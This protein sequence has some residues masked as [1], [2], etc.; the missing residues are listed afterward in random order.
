MPSQHALTLAAGDYYI[1]VDPNAYAE[2]NI[3]FRVNCPGL[4]PC[5]TSP[6]YPPNNS[7]LAV[8]GTG[9]VFTWPAAFGATSYDVYFQGNYVANTPTN[10]INGGSGYSTANIAA[11]FGIGN[12]ITWRVVPRNSFGEADCPTN[13]TFRVG[14]NGSAN[15]IPLSEGVVRSGNIR[16]SNG[17]TSNNSNNWGPDAWYVFTASPCA[18]AVTVN[19]CP[20]GGI[21]PSDG[22]T[23]SAN[24]FASVTVRRV[25]DN[26]QVLYMEDNS[27]GV[28][29]GCVTVYN[30]DLGANM[31]PSFTVNPDES[32]Y[33]IADGYGWQY[34]FDLSFVETVDASD[35][36][37]DGIPDCAD[38][39]VETPGEI[40]DPCYAGPLF[41]SGVVNEN[42][43]CE[44]QDPQPCNNDL[45]LEFQTDDAPWDI[46]WE[47]VEQGTNFVVQQGGPL[48]PQ[49]SVETNFTC[50]PD[51][52]FYLRVLDAAGDGMTT[53]GYILRN[54]GDNSR[55]IDNR[56]N[57]STGEVSQIAGGQGFCLPIG[58]DK[59]IYSSCD[60]LDWVAN[61]F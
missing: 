37:G 21:N 23:Y 29:A 35:F 49:N 50:L 24:G 47:L 3:T 45:T 4:P 31:P 7:T 9:T 41:G 16:A 59:L 38:S 17:F 48:N 28:T 56:N 15:A 58:D 6:T 36:D 53:G 19:L 51:G 34:N 46:T 52:C 57:F 42:C 20:T 61:K 1:L 14:G 44:G 18:T 39:C 2:G 27:A 8:T 40:G 43:E 25:T 32:Y 10:S 12:T 60:K 26:S 11:L 55:I 13:Y 30:F 22:N 54:S 33:I 5:V